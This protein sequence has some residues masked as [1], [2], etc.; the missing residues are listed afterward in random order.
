[1]LVATISAFIAV[2]A[3]QNDSDIGISTRNLVQVI[4]ILYIIIASYRV[5]NTDEEGYSSFPSQLSMC[6]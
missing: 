4:W 2:S 6:L 5:S 3:Q 1:M